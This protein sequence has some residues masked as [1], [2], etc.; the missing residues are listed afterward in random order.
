VGPLYALFE[1]AMGG[2]VTIRVLYFEVYA[3]SYPTV[4][5]DCGG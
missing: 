5:S 3:H 1:S 4:V 2:L